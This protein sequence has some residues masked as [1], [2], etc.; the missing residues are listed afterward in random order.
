[1]KRY[2]I[3][4]MLATGSIVHGSEMPVRVDGLTLTEACQRDIE[5]ARKKIERQDYS[6]SK[7]SKL[8]DLLNGLFL[9]SSA[10][11]DDE[12]AQNVHLFDSDLK[13]IEFR[14]ALILAVYTFLDSAAGKNSKYFPKKQ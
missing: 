4:L 10:I 8:K 1:M 12:L 7:S 5:N 9:T 14:K 11:A 2:I 13:R 6:N 3:A